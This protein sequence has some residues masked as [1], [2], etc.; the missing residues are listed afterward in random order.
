MSM[1]GQYS[2]RAITLVKPRRRVHGTV[3]LPASTG[4]GLQVI[5]ESPGRKMCHFCC[6]SDKQSCSFGFHSIP[7]SHNRNYYVFLALFLL[8]MLQLRNV[9][10]G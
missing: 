4:I 1:Q 6:L 5:P 9:P 8:V 2:Y 7:T 10:C 3:S